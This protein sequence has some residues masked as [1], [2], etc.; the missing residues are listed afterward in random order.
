MT[1]NFMSAFDYWCYPLLFDLE[2]TSKHFSYLLVLLS[3][4]FALIDNS[5]SLWLWS[6][7]AGLGATHGALFGT[8]TKGIGVSIETRCRAKTRS[9]WSG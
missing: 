4:L 2:A 7:A 5:F 8:R 3:K 6:C 9:R 1:D